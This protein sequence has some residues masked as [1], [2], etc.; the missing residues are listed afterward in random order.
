MLLCYRPTV[1]QGVLEKSCL[2]ALCMTSVPMLSCLLS[3]TPVLLGAQASELG[4]STEVSQILQL[5]FVFPSEFPLSS[6]HLGEVLLCLCCPCF[7]LLLLLFNSTDAF[8]L[9]FLFALLNT[10]VHCVHVFLCDTSI[11]LFCHNSKLEVAASSDLWCAVF[12]LLSSWS[13][14]HSVVQPVFCFQVNL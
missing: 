14:Y 12:F 10:S 4:C 13:I 11:P 8:H 1:T 3:L 9:V 2:C 7:C 6:H 5:G